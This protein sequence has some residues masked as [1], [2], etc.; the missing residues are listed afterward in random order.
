MR[1][2]ASSSLRSSACPTPTSAKRS[3]RSS[4]R[5]SG[6]ALTEADVIAALKGEIA[7]FKVPKR[8]HFVDGAA[9]QRDGQ[10]PEEP[11]AR[12]LHEARRRARRLARL[13]RRPRCHGL[14]QHVRRE[15]VQ[16]ERECAL[17]RRAPASGGR[18]ARRT[19][20]RSCSP[21]RSRAARAGRHSRS[22]TAAV[23]SA[24]PGEDE[25][26]R[27]RGGDRAGRA[28]PK[29][30]RSCASGRCTRS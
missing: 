23:P 22:C 2:T 10:G 17:E 18:R 14:P 21:R 11:V 7:R 29:S 8:V 16:H 1:C 13:V 24:R 15:R 12:A 6:H 28:P 9:A 19:A 26:D 20:R 27:R 5:Q 30:R 4:S 3:R 25:T